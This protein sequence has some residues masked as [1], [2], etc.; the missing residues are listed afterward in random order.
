VLCPCPATLALRKSSQLMPGKSLKSLPA[1]LYKELLQAAEIS[2]RH[3]WQRID[4]NVQNGRLFIN[5]PQEDR[6]L[7]PL[8]RIRIILQLFVDGTLSPEDLLAR[9]RLGDVEALLQPEIVDKTRLKWLTTGAPVNGGAASGRIAFSPKAVGRFKS[10]NEPA[11]LVVDYISRRDRGIAQAAGVLIPYLEKYCHTGQLCKTL[12]LP[13]VAARFSFQGLPGGEQGLQ[14][15]GCAPLKEGDW[16]TLDGM[17]CDVLAGRAKVERKPWR[18]RAELLQLWLILRHVVYSGHVPP[19]CA[20][21]VWRI[22][23]LLRHGVRLGSP[24]RRVGVA[25]KRSKPPSLPPLQNADAMR[26]AMSKI[27][28]DDTPVI[29]GL[30]TAI[31]RQFRAVLGARCSH[32]YSRPLWEPTIGARSLGAAQ[33]VGFELFDIDRYIPH[34]LGICRIRFLIECVAHSPSEAWRF[35]SAGPRGFRIIQGSGRIEACRVEVNGALLEHQDLP[36]FYTWLRRREYVT[37]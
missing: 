12:G 15:P 1:D 34:L 23:D 37:D 35:E 10:A 6:G 20:G 3:L 33:L 4:F 18:S 17:T 31:E 16:L 9:I 5:P 30:V 32:L 27:A 11:I 24:Q 21:S 29:L 22:W 7:S 2:D 8:A 26:Q 14:F 36:K 13:S 28:A 19:A 25:R